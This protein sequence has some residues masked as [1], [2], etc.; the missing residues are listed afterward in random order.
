MPQLYSDGVS[1]CDVLYLF[2]QPTA[3]IGNKRKY[4]RRA[5]VIFTYL[6][7]N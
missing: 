3:I 7:E 1:E 4:A 5:L 2:E 6:Q